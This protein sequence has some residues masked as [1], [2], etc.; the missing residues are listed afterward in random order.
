MDKENWLTQGFEE[1]RTHLSA[2]A[3]RMLGSTHEA[4]DAVQ[5][6]WIRLSRSDAG[7]IDNVRGWLSTVVARICLDMLRARKAK[8]EET[9]DQHE[10]SAIKDGGAL[11]D[12]GL[13]LADTVGPA[14]LAV[15]D[16]L[17]PAERI[18]FVLHDLFDIPFRDIAP[19]IDRNE[20]ATRQL[21]SR[22]R[23]RVRGADIPG[24]DTERQQAVVAAFMAASREGDF[25]ALIRLLHPDVVLRADEAA[26]RITTTNKGKGA[27]QFAHRLTGA[28]TVAETFKGKALGAELATIDGLTGMTWAPPGGKPVFA[29]CFTLGGGR[30]TAIDVVMDQTTLREMDIRPAGNTAP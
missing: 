10:L 8:R 26:I 3:F 5:E 16:L 18:A 4:E 19:I 7:A 15:L 20:M 28:G 23:R 1:S 9:L 29:W 17:A 22:A 14:L 21:A 2:V 25:D 6:A 11:P 12:D 30:I 24:E 13:Q 27:P